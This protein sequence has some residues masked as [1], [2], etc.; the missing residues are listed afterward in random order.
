MFMYFFDD[1]ITYTGKELQS[2]WIYRKTKKQGDAIVSFIGKCDVPLEHMV[3]I[4]DVIAKEPIYSKKML[5]FI[6]ET[7]NI[8]LVEGVFRQRLLVEKAVD[9]LRE[10]HDNKL[11]IKR[12]GDDIFINGKKASVSIATKS[13]TSVLIHFAINIVSKGAIIEVASLND[14]T[15]ISD[16][17]KFA[18]KL[19]SDY[20]DEV[21]DILLATT[22]V[23]GV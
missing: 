10:L 4:E 8:N 22:K 14:D 18:K 12:K 15:K 20:N 13:L 19:M 7:F 17:K 6:I 2:H 21:E 3:D 23:S 11:D 16:I 9:L 1:E 5:H